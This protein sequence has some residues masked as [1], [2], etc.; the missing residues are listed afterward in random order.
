M[1]ISN[2]FLQNLSNSIQQNLS[3]FIR[4]NEKSASRWGSMKNV[5]PTLSC[6]LKSKEFTRVQG[7]LWI[8]WSWIGPPIIAKW[9]SQANMNIDGLVPA[10]LPLHDFTAPVA[11]SITSSISEA[12]NACK[13]PAV[14]SSTQSLNCVWH[15]DVMEKDWSLFG[16]KHRP[17]TL[18]HEAVLV[19]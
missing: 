16:C 4:I 17:S 12:N 7:D 15:I 11:I 3:K 6:K 18:L 10:C 1:C 5:S 8:S 13:S 19:Q 14:F 2:G 9:A